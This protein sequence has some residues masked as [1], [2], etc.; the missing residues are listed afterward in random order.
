MENDK[1]CTDIDTLRLMFAPV[2]SG[3]FTF[4]MPSC[5]GDSSIIIAKTD[6]NNAFTY[7]LIHFYWSFDTK[8]RFES[9]T[10]DFKNVDTIVARWISGSSHVVR[11]VTENKYGCLSGVNATTINE[12]PVLNPSKTLTPTTCHQ[13]NG[14][15]VL[16]NKNNLYQFTWDN[17]FPALH[18]HD[19]VQSNL[20]NKYYVVMVYGESISPDAQPGTFC[21]D[22]LKI[23]VTDTGEVTAKF[24]TLAFLDT[25]HSVD[26]RE[27]TFENQTIGGN[28]YQWLFYDDKGNK[29]GESNIENPVYT[30]HKGAY[31]IILIAE[32]K[33]NCVDTVMYKYLIVKSKSLIEVP[34]VFS[35]NGDGQND[36]FIIKNQTLR[37]FHCTIFNRWGII[38]YE[39]TDPAKGWDGKMKS[40]AEA[41]SG[42]YYYI[43]TG[44]GEDN[45]NYVNKGSLELFREAK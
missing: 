2:P 8:A 15:I 3:L 40:G 41:I 27:V 10:S 35:P 21:L 36:E 13:S 34:N 26:P 32:S 17:T 12:P 20:S 33:F 7:G 23:M 22:S 14:K 44:V 42:V 39:W 45:V 28:K 31:K 1:G 43:I 6:Q 29:I 38:I 25:I 4:T 5:K 19:T 30:F 16:H 9:D 24:D 18:R 11:L 37:D